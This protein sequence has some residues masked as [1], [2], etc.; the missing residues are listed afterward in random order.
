MGAR[1]MTDA[2]FREN[3]YWMRMTQRDYFKTRD[4]A[5]LV[6][7]KRLEKIVDDEL[8]GEKK[9]PMESGEG[10]EG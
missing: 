2:E 7:S 5:W 8:R 1:A 6:E 3:V 4:A 9:L 10:E